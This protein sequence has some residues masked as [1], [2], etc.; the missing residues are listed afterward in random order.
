MILV[1][2]QGSVTDPRAPGKKFSPAEQVSK[3][4]REKVTLRW[5]CVFQVVHF[6]WIL[7]YVGECMK[8]RREGL[9]E[10]GKG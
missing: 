4:N 6:S 8:G 1:Q 2:R 9:E 3:S 7:E 5:M 10:G